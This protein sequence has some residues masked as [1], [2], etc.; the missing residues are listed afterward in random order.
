MG[1]APALPQAGR[2][3]TLVRGL[4]TG[5]SGMM[6]QQNRLDTI[7][8]NLANVDLTGYKKDTAVFKAFP[9]M[10]MRRMNDDGVQVFP[11]G[12][13]D[14]TPIVG[15]VGTGVELNEVFTNF[16]QG[17]LKQT[18]NDFDMALD[19]KGFLTVQTEGGERYTRNGSFLVDS[20]GFLVTKNG[21]KVLGE[22]GPVRLKLNNFVVDQDGAIWQ[23]ARFAGNPNRLVS[24]QENE[25]DQL[26]KVDRLKIV[27]VD[28][29]RYLAKE[30]NSNWRTT[31]ESGEARVLDGGERPRVRQ[32]FIESSNVNSVTEMVDMIEVN[33]AYEANQKTIQTEDSLLGKLFNEVM[34][35]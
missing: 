12:S 30:G 15:T 8:N 23:N 25:W 2:R 11:M 26:E 21:D 13:V 20:D 10:L 33:R 28:R 24:M 5:A 16:E 18:E 27:T 7:A 32:G 3:R 19:G 4:Y 31:E 17:A 14:T 29:T 35:V 34:K 9:Q 22:N 1:A 6:V